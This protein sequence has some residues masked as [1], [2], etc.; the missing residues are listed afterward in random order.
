MISIALYDKDGVCIAENR[1]DQHVHQLFVREYKEGDRFVLYTDRK[2]HL[3]VK[4]DSCIESANVYSTGGSFEYPI[5]F[6]DDRLPYPVGAFEGEYH[7]LDVMQIQPE[8]RYE[9]RDISTNPLD[10]REKTTVFPHCTASIETR[11]E[12]IFAARNTID[13]LKETDGHGVWP[14]TSWGDNEDSNAEIHIDFGRKVVMNKLIINLRSDFPHDNYW[15]Q[16]DIL[17]GNGQ[18]MTLQL[19]KTG[20]DQCFDL[21][22][23]I[24]E[25]VKLCRLIKDE[26]DPSPFPALTHWQ[27]I[28]RECDN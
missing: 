13:G 5:P 23:I 1:N 18:T 28:G 19:N 26:N 24:A 11:G 27:I 2:Q 4:L 12:S 22:G 15:K 10:V 6:G 25:S 17:F 21:K 7:I 20:I 16:V 8:L 14:F 9:D 3:R